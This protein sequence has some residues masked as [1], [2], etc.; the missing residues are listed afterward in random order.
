MMISDRDPEKVT[1]EDLL[2]LKRAERPSPEFWA[3]FEQD[4]RVKQLAAIVEKRP[5]WCTLRLPQAG[6]LLA[7]FQVPVGAAAILA[8]SLVTLAEYR[9][10]SVSTLPALTSPVVAVVREPIAKPVAAPVLVAEAAHVQPASM[11]GAAAPVPAA[12]EASSVPAAASTELTAMIPWGIAQNETP[13]SSAILPLS[14]QA[15]ETSLEGAPTSVLASTALLDNSRDAEARVLPARVAV[16]QEKPPAAANTS[17]RELRRTRLMAGLVLADNSDGPDN[18]RV[19]HGRELVTSGLNEDQL[20]DSVHR[21]GLGGDRL[22]LK[23]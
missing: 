18:A 3:R 14:V 13:A 15:D 1:L 16:A 2:R 10:E 9:S 19:S 12:A 8:L 7:R 23:F 22:T 4:L 11:A 20:Y 6:R 17:P 5:W 21:V